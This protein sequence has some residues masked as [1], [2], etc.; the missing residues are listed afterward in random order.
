MDDRDRSECGKAAGPFTVSVALD[1]KGVSHGSPAQFGYPYRGGD[2]LPEPELVLEVN[3][4]MYPGDPRKIVRQMERTKKEFSLGS[5]HPA[6]DGGVVVMARGVGVHPLHIAHYANARA[7]AG[8]SFHGKAPHAR[9]SKFKTIAAGTAVLSGPCPGYSVRFTSVTTSEYSEVY[10]LMRVGADP[11]QCGTIG[12]MMMR[13][14]RFDEE[15]EIDTELTIK[16]LLEEEFKAC[17][18]GTTPSTAAWAG[19]TFS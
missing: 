11:D 5:L 13:G 10:L 16:G 19:L 2:D 14:S 9:S 15:V 3:F 18:W 6:H 1:L 12:E 4:L 8:H 7:Y 17:V